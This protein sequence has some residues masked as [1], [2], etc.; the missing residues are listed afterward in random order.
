V[1]ADRFKLRQK[2]SYERHKEKRIASHIKWQK[3]NP[4]RVAAINKR[5]REKNPKNRARTMKQWREKNR[6]H[7]IT[8]GNAYKKARY[9]ADPE[10]S[11][12]K[13]R[14]AAKRR[15]ERAFE[16]GGSVTA[17]EVSALIERQ[18]GLC[19]TRAYFKAEWC[20]GDIRDKFDLD[21]RISLVNGGSGDIS[22][23]QAMCSPCNKRKQHRN[24][25]E[26]IGLL[27]E[28][29]VSSGQIRAPELCDL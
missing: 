19:A 29:G 4:E 9:H 5:S 22:N 3:K 15:R 8:Y 23:L 10:R 12:L 14:L 6:E 21:H 27:L 11:R 25:T 2:A 17:A 24:M 18:N 20:L 13:G 7:V 28:T 1:N 16:A 26:W